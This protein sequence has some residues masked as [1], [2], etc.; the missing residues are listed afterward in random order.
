MSTTFSDQAP[1]SCRGFFI[2]D[3][4]GLRRT[5]SPLDSHHVSSRRLWP[6]PMFSGQGAERSFQ[7]GRTSFTLSSS[8]GGNHL[9]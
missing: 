7:N 1:A 5:R 6:W 2:P 9:V 4:E 8:R 3:S